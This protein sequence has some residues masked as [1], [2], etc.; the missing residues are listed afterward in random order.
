M[1]STSLLLDAG[2]AGAATERKHLFIVIRSA[3]PPPFLEA[4]RPFGVGAFLITALCTKCFLSYTF[5]AYHIHLM[6]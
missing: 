5:N 1:D 2:K 6:H 4:K 3:R